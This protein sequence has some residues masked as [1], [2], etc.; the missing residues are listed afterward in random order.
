M[1]PAELDA[2]DRSALGGELNR[3]GTASDLLRR[4]EL[5]YRA[6]T[7]LSQVGTLDPG[8]LGSPEQAEQVELAIEVRAKYAGQHVLARPDRERDAAGVQA[9]LGTGYASSAHAERCV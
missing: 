5:S 4:P 9:S 1:R 8:V 7:G 2:A 6:V 3:E